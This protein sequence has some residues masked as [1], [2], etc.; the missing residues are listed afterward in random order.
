MNAKQI[1][2]GFVQNT[3]YSS[4]ADS[5]SDSPLLLMVT[6]TS[7]PL[8]RTARQIV[9]EPFSIEGPAAI[10]SSSATPDYPCWFTR[11]TAVRKKARNS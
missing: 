2:T 11:P 4:Y 3:S 6:A 8:V 7:L 10:R 5:S 1:R 9:F